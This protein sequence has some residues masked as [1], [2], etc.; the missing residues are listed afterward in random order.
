MPLTADIYLCGRLQ[1]HAGERRVH[2]IPNAVIIEGSEAAHTHTHTPAKELFQLRKRGRLQIWHIESPGRDPGSG[3]QSKAHLGFGKKGGSALNTA[4]PPDRAARMLLDSIVRITEEKMGQNDHVCMWQHRCGCQA[5]RGV[6]L[7]VKQIKSP[8]PALQCAACG[9]DCPVQPACPMWGRPATLATQPA[10]PQK[11]QPAAWAIFRTGT[12]PAGASKKAPP[13][14]HGGRAC[15]FVAPA[16][17]L[18]RGPSVS[19]GG[20]VLPLL[21]KDPG[22]GRPPLSEREGTARAGRKPL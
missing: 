11:H 6:N 12:C 19:S 4:C 21:P 9:E 7:E 14:A 1:S 20:K 3:G 13:Q 10:R 15:A 16:A 8:T 17:P 22:I 5:L 18:G 2:C